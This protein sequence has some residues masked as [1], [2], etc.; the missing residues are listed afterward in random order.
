VSTRLSVSDSEHRWRQRTV[1]VDV[2]GVEVTFTVS[3]GDDRKP[4]LS[5]ELPADAPW[6]TVVAALKVARRHVAGDEGESYPRPPA[7]PAAQHLHDAA[8]RAR[9]LLPG[10]R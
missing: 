5:L 8:E 6:A 10:R 7:S 4:R 1:R 2:D 9:R 3:Q